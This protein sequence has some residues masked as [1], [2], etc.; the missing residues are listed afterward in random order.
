MSSFIESKSH[1]KQR[2]REVGLDQATVRALEDCGI[3]T[4]SR[5]AYSIGRPGQPVSQSEF[6]EFVTAH[7]SHASVGET[8]DSG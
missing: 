3:T 6:D 4:L 7:L 1:F 8:A 2:C 5:L